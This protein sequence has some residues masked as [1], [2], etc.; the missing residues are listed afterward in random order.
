MHHAANPVGLSGVPV[1]ALPQGHGHAHALV[2]FKGGPIS[3][4][5]GNGAGHDDHRVRGLGS[6]EGRSQI[7]VLIIDQK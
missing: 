4:F 3:I 2:R 1:K 6:L 5:L 7:A